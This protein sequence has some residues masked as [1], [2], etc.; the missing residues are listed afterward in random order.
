MPV[1]AASPLRK[2][3]IALACAAPVLL[4]GGLWWLMN[5]VLLVPAI[6]TEKTTEEQRVAFFVDD[7]GLRRLEPGQAWTFLLSQAQLLGGDE[8]R[9][10]QFVKVLRQMSGEEQKAFGDAVIN[11]AMPKLLTDAKTFAELR[12]DRATAWLDDHIVEYKRLEVLVRSL[13]VNR[14]ARGN[15]ALDQQMLTKMVT[16]R[17][18]PQDQ[19]R[20]ATYLKAIAQRLAEILADTELKAKFE[21][22]IGA[23]LG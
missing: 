11:V 6:P 18:T 23:T 15:L 8:A 17:L 13:K 22:K 1:P 9:R 5:A 19:E 2:V 3:L 16:D 12:D 4:L 20:G 21:A 7:R 14:E 10:G